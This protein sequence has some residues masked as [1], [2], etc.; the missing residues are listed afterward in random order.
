MARTEKM[1][2]IAVTDY[3]LLLRRASAETLESIWAS[4]QA[5]VPATARETLGKALRSSLIKGE[6]ERRGLV[7]P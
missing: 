1:V 2:T 7:V 6:F 3:V 4:I 5:I